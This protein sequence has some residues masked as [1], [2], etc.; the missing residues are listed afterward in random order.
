MGAE[1]T[2]IF[3]LVPVRK[4]EKKA[5]ADGHRLPA[6]GTKEGTGFELI[7]SSLRLGGLGTTGGMLFHSVI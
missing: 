4:N 6:A 1:G 2:E 7:I 3:I 5:F